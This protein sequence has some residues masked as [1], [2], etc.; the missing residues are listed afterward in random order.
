MIARPISRRAVLEATGLAA[1]G[2][3]FLAC[4]GRRGTS[5]VRPDVARR[6]ARVR[7]AEDRII[8]TVVGLRPYR[9]SGFLVR[10]EKIGEKT[11]VHNYGHG[12]GGITLSWGTSEIAVEEAWK[13]GEK[14]FAVLGCGAV[15]L[16]TARLLQERGAEV[17]IYAKDLPPHTTSNIA[18]GQWSPT[19][20]M[21]AERRTAESDALL[22][23]AARLS[24]RSYQRLPAAEFGI[25]WLENYV[26]S[27]EPLREWWEQSLVSDLYP[28]SRELRPDEHP[29]PARHARRFTTMLIEPLIYLGAMVR[30][31]RL[32]G[33]RIVVRR[34]GG[35]R[36]SAGASRARDRQLH[37][38]REPRPSSATTS[39]EPVKGQLTFLL[40][41][42]EVDYIVIANGLYMFPRRDG[43]LLGGTFEH[44]VSRLDVNEEARQRILAGHR[45][46]FDGMR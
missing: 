9:R 28:G 21:D 44:D 40:P 39:S 2:A 12:G 14:R 25:R 3:G 5:L 46:L 1:L 27:D 11:V 7:V 19:S 32:A 36:G 20:V 15:G 41:Q 10:A 13:T 33:G 37:G 6:F 34:A 18:G 30:E 45:A 42:D 38:P 24:H 43:I 4:A 26:L 17:T 29:F 8:R 22:A 31:V 16:G 23:R 35:P